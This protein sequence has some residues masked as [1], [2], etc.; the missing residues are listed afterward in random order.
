MG[1][2]TSIIKYVKHIF[3]FSDCYDSEEDK[4]NK[5]KERSLTNTK[6]AN[7]EKE[8]ENVKNLSEGKE[9]K[10]EEEYCFLFN[11]TKLRHLLLG[12]PD[13]SNLFEIIFTIS[14]HLFFGVIA[15][16]INAEIWWLIGDCSDKMNF[17]IKNSTF[18]VKNPV[19]VVKFQ[20]RFS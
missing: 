14:R 18:C 6:R 11:E 1:G 17:L 7:L 20:I 12:V 8:K 10:F 16:W 9:K 5:D 13:E 2:I 15:K 3:D 19:E 4:L